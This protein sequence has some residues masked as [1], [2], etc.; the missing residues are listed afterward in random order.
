MLTTTSCIG[1][2]NREE[3][4]AA[5]QFRKNLSMALSNLPEIEVLHMANKIITAVS[6]LNRLT[7]KIIYHE[8]LH[9]INRNPRN[10]DNAR[11]PH[12]IIDLYIDRIMGEGTVQQQ[13]GI[14]AWISLDELSRIFMSVGDF[15]YRAVPEKLSPEDQKIRRAIHAIIRGIQ[16][17]KTEII[18]N[19]L[20]KNL[21]RNPE[22]EDLLDRHLW[23]I[24]RHLS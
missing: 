18:R 2:D 20:Q 7:A 14:H 24:E 5:D 17:R 6:H 23:D 9:L 8:V 21:L 11:I 15:L 16:T 22:I 1:E 19:E 10:I 12:T 3:L 13:S 4:I